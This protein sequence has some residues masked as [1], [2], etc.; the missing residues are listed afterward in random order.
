MRPVN[1]EPDNPVPLHLAGN[2]APV[3]EETRVVPTEV[4]GAIPADLAGRFLR[5]GPNPRTGWSSHLYD[6]DGMIHAIALEDGTARWYRNRY[7]R[8]PLYEN[9]GVSRFALAFDRATGRID[10]RVTT[11]NTHVI[12]H[13]GR[14]LALE[15]GGFPYEIA[16][17]LDTGD[18]DTVGP[19]TFGGALRTPMTAHPKR[20]PVTGGLLFFGYQLRPPFLTYHRASATGRLEASE[21]ITLPA[22]TMM[23]DFAIT[24]TRAV[25]MDSPIV[26]DAAGAAAG[27]SPWRW[28][29]D[30][31]ARFGVMPRSGG[32]AD[33]RWFELAPGHLSHAANAYDDGPDR[34]VVTGTRLPRVTD[35]ASGVPGAGLP[36]V[37][38]WTVD[39]ATGTV[40]ESP[41]DDAPSE[42]PRIADSHVS[43]A[44]RYTYTASFVLDALPDRSTIH[45]YDVASGRRTD[46]VLP[47]GHTCGEPVFVASAGSTA[48]DDGYLLTFAHDRARGMSHLLIV[49]AADVGSPPL[50]AVHLP[51]RVP[52]GFHGTWIAG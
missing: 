5:N 21:P 46:H 48:E 15:E 25:F 2:N 43:R 35:P 20:C 37:Y 44:N 42:Y 16:V 10:H 32:D 36:V 23:H 45:K 1:A 40:T 50:A 28:D 9:P 51:V 6:G 7:V 18:L 8:A 29:D 27:G 30:H 17:D 4:R 19:F 31:P 24:S 26:L 52:A 14:T 22:A 33:I 13:A 49:D 34:V 47:L 39:L 41:V 3:A 12:D 11:A 38:R